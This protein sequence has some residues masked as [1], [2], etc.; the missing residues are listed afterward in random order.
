MAAGHSSNEIKPS[1]RNDL[2]GKW[3]VD[4]FDNPR[5]FN[6]S[7]SR[8]LE[9]SNN[10]SL[11]SEC[12]LNVSVIVSFTARLTS[13]DYLTVNTSSD[14]VSIE[15]T[16]SLPQ[17]SRT[18]GLAPASSIKSLLDYWTFFAQ[19]GSPPGDLLLGSLPIRRRTPAVI[20]TSFTRREVRSPVFIQWARLDCA[21]RGC[22]VLGIDTQFM[23]A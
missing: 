18:Y 6:P 16:H 17:I 1:D 19:A 15:Q 3:N 13:V 12:P 20:T 23:L 5:T 9:T 2:C 22:R 14:T 21:D 7:V 4:R 10:L 11:L 8:N